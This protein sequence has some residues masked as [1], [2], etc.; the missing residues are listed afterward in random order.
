MRIHFSILARLAFTVF[1]FKASIILLTEDF[2]QLLDEVRKYSRHAIII[3]LQHFLILIV[4]EKSLN[5]F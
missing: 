4:K 2:L 1:R 3:F 5:A